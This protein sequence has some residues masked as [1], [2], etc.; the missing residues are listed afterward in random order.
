MAPIPIRRSMGGDDD[1]LRVCRFGGGQI[2]SLY[3][4]RRE[5]VGHDRIVDEFPEDGGRGGGGK[6]FGCFNCIAN[7]EAHAEVGS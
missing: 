6:C 1:V 3:A 2:C 7:A 5:L 4:Q